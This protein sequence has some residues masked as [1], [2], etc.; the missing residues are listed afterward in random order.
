MGI[1][2]AT[3][4]SIQSIVQDCRFY[5]ACSKIK[6]DLHVHGYIVYILGMFS[7][8]IGKVFWCTFNMLQKR[9]QDLVFCAKPCTGDWY[10]TFHSVAFYAL[11][12]GLVFW[13]MVMVAQFTGLVITA[14]PFIYSS[15]IDAL[16]RTLSRV[17][18]V[19]IRLYWSHKCMNSKI[20]QVNQLPNTFLFPKYRRQETRVGMGGV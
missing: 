20:C 15:H 11:K 16:P 8:Y 6:F 18:H 13:G 2:K 3:R 17:F 14:N 1:L 10:N 5:A 9:L 7:C 19:E 4:E 12:F